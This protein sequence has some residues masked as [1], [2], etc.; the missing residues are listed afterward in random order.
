[1]TSPLEPGDENFETASSQL[2]AGLRTCRTVL[3][4]YRSLLAGETGEDGAQ[5]SFTESGERDEE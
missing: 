1:M 3:S 4:N 2:D 5:A